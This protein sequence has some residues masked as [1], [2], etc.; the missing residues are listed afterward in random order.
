MEILNTAAGVSPAAYRICQSIDRMEAPLTGAD[1]KKVVPARCAFMLELFRRTGEQAVWNDLITLA[2]Q[3]K[4]YQE[5]PGYNYTLYGGRMGIAWFYLGLYRTSGENQWL[6]EA[7]QIAM[8]YLQGESFRYSIIAT[9]GVATGL[10]GILL[11]LLH[12]YK[13]TQDPEI[14][15][16]LEKIVLQ[17][18][19]RAKQGRKGIHW[20]N[21]T[22]C[23]G[24]NTGFKNGAAG[25]ALVLSEV[26]RYFS[27][28]IL[29]ALAA[30]ALE[31]EA[32]YQAD[33][34][35]AGYPGSE[36]QYGE[37]FFLLKYMQLMETENGDGGLPEGLP[38]RSVF[39]QDGYDILDAYL[40]SAYRRT[41]S[42][43]KSLR[44]NVLQ[45]YYSEYG[46]PDI[47]AFEKYIEAWLAAAEEHTDV[48]AVRVE[49]EREQFILSVRRSLGF[50]CRPVADDE[51]GV[52]QLEAQMPLSTERFLSL[53]LVHAPSVRTRSWEETMDLSRVLTVPA[54]ASFFQHYGARFCICYLSLDDTLQ[55]INP[56][57][58][59][60]VFE[61]FDQ[62]LTI[63]EAAQR[64]VTFIQ[65]QPAPALALLKDHYY[66]TDDEQL[67]GKIVNL[68]IDGARLHM[69]EGILVTT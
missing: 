2:A 48:T 60:L 29:E 32:D 9:S 4:T 21:A 30:K 28:G 45:A 15:E 22:N 31:Y 40:Q 41:C 55:D 43:L 10:A 14:L 52:E 49:F 33:P 66:V 51:A 11:V 50:R 53:R 62:P 27:S 59:R 34:V 3:L 58:I 64:I 17:L 44:P 7:R 12:V 20:G 36:A 26:S 39:R 23:E 18:A 35:S 16:G 42:L 6:Q 56:G 46:M 13:E 69:A 68:V 1:I 63:R 61:Q 67:F 37:G 54:F 19:F 38:L 8:D 5:S 47:A 65:Q 24:A 25:I 57:I